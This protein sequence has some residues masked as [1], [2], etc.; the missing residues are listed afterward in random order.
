MD[1][2]A[3]DHPWDAV[4]L[5]DLRRRR[6]A[7]WRRYPQDVLPAWV[8]EMDLPLAEPVRAALA[9]LVERSDTGYVDSFGDRTARAWAGYAERTWGQRLD[10]GLARVVPDVVRGLEVALAAVSPVGAPVVVDSPSYPPFVHVLEATGRPMVRVP[11]VRGADQRWV[12]DLEAVAAAYA[13]GARV[14]LL[15]NPQNPTGSVLRPDELLALADLAERHGVLVVADEIHAPLVRQG[16]RFTPFAALDH[17]AARRA[18]TLV[19]AS[20]AW[21]LAGLKCA[22]LLAGDDGGA[23][24]LS[25]VPAEAT[26]GASLF[27]QVA[28]EAALTDGGPWLAELLAYLDTGFERLDA[29]LTEHLPGVRWTRPEGTYLAWLD[30]RG[31]GL[32]GDEAVNPAAAFLS[33]GRVALGTGTD[34]GPEG[35]GHVRLTAGV[36]RPLLDELVRR[37][38]AALPGR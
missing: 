1:R 10:P 17:P 36:P 8:A 5:A 13:A 4:T 31:L 11:L 2:L 22:L 3:L 23:D 20:K 16:V 27:G 24:L 35:A 12:P 21:N 29:L 14:H 26:F 6:S 38:A 25:A 34:F 18:V 32:A 28:T 15:C 30:C 19:S 37:M 7:K 33:R 9:D